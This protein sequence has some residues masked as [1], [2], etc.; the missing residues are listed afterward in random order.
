MTRE[1]VDL[2]NIPY[3][4]LIAGEVRDAFRS[5]VRP[6]G[7]R[8]D[9]PLSAE[10]ADGVGDQGK[11]GP[12]SGFD[13]YMEQIYDTATKGVRHFYACWRVI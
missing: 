4:R 7:P 12:R 3:A 5:K 9:A 11:V 6:R 13:S 2:S 1:K 8:R 10:D